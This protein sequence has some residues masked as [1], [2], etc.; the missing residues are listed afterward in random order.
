[1]DIPLSWILLAAFA[2]GMLVSAVLFL[3][4]L[5]FARQCQPGE[6]RSLALASS[7]RPTERSRWLR[8]A[9]RRVALTGLVVLAN[10]LYASSAI[11]QGSLRHLDPLLFVACQMIL[12][13][14]VALALLWRSRRTASLA[15]VRLGLQGGVVLGIGFVL[16]ALSLR[17]LGVLPTAMLMAL[18]GVM[19]S[20]ISW[21]VFRQRPSVATCLAVF[22]AMGGAFLLWWIAPGLWQADMVA[23]SGGLCFTLY[24]FH[25]ERAGI[26]RLVR[27]QQRAFFGGLVSAM[28]AVALALALGFGAWS[29]VHA[30]TLPDLEIVCYTSWAT[31]L[32][33][34]L[35]STSLLRS[36]SAVTLSFAAI[37]EP[38]IS[39]GFAS[40]LGAL[41]LPWLGWLGVGSIL[42][43]VLIQA[44][45]AATS[46]PSPARNKQ[47]G[48]DQT[49]AVL[50]P[51]LHA[52]ER[53]CGSS[54]ASRDARETELVA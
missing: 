25:V 17:S 9:G 4:V 44:G 35:I 42:L 38:L 29:S 32:L 16:T 43:S 48:S 49:P 7:A 21:L 24:A 54:A 45:A 36:I 47:G 41:S 27:H 11:A 8:A 14:P 39:L 3:L 1:M 31:V 34:V 37:L 28:A 18:N 50:V 53:V 40:A 26:V 30:F 22:C 2:A 13:L 15:I 33:P 5:L 6:R 12:L 20:G 10:A 19:A 46:H 23:L 51:D 52:H